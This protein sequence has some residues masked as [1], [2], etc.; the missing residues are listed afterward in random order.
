MIV[1]QLGGAPIG[2]GRRCLWTHPVQSPPRLETT[3]ATF[4]PRRRSLRVFTHGERSSLSVNLLSMRVAW[5]MYCVVSA[6]YRL[7]ANTG[8]HWVWPG[9]I[10]PRIRWQSD[11]RWHLRQRMIDTLLPPAITYDGTLFARPMLHRR[12]RHDPHDRC[13]CREGSNV[14]RVY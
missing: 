9:F 13:R 1:P 12:V 7:A 4:R 3:G 11:L 14:C 6:S 8:A 5:C 10:L 2:N